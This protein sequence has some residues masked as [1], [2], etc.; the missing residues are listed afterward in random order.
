M[1][2][3]IPSGNLTRAVAAAALFAVAAFSTRSAFAASAADPEY[4][5]GARVTV[6]GDK[7]GGLSQFPEAPITI[8]KTT[9]EYQVLIPAG[10]KTAYCKGPSMDKLV[11]T[12]FAL[13]PSAGRSYDRVS[14]H[15]TSTWTDPASG[16]LYGVFTAN[17]SDEVTRI[18]GPGIGYRGRY[19]TVAL[20]K[21][22][23]GGVGFTK[24]GPILSIPKNAT[25]SAMQGDAFGTVVMS[26]DKK[27]LYIYYGDMYNGQMV[28]GIQTCVARATVES[29]GLPGS[30]KKWYNGGWNTQGNSIIDSIEY[31]GAETTPVITNT[32]SLYGDAMYP[33]VAYSA[34][35][36]LYVMVYA[37][38]IFDE[39][40]PADSLGGYPPTELSGIY[41]AYSQDA[42]SW[43]GQQQLFKSI[44]IDYPGREVALHPTI[45]LDENGSSATTLKATVY[46]GYNANMWWGTPVTQFLA[47]RSVNVTGLSAS[48]F[49]SRIAPPRMGH[50][51]PGFSV[52]GYS[53]LKDGAGEILIRFPQDRVQDL[54]VVGADGV[55][56]GNV[57]SQGNGQ[58]R[59]GLTQSSGPLFLQGKRDGRAFSGYL[60]RN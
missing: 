24:I 37:I 31:T 19:Y 40:P 10:M 38:N 6:L 1:N 51:A 28:G 45:A 7:A 5:V 60:N 55:S 16:E 54:R 29:K 44:T 48:L 15:I 34:K 27:Y 30:W 21:S 22:T 14:A 2:Q 12:G 43:G 50:A 42:V 25:S 56:V 49:P 36:G 57:R 17:D 32:V 53:V 41:I 4:K 58:Y 3:S 52:L 13:S 33:H 39:T 23:N 35:L 20:A 46:Y 47:S 11:A 59:V 9:P 8:L 26:P 18:P